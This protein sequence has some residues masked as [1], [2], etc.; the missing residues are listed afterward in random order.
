M[1]SLSECVAEHR[2]RIKPIPA[3]RFQIVVKSFP[4]QRPMPELCS[5]QM[6][7]PHRAG[8][9]CTPLSGVYDPRFCELA[10]TRRCSLKVPDA[11][12]HSSPI[13]VGNAKRDANLQRPTSSSARSRAAS[14]E[15]IIMV[16]S[17]RTPIEMLCGIA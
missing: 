16:P 8:R 13:H 6:Y 7:I 10:A 12:S 15:E 14:H 17:P 4:V 11:A 9:N 1:I 3:S 5:A 2:M